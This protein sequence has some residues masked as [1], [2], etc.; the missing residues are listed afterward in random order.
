MKNTLRRTIST[1]LRAEAL[2]EALKDLQYHTSC[3]HLSP[4]DLLHEANAA[5][6]RACHL[7]CNLPS[8]P[9]TMHEKHAHFAIRNLRRIIRGS[10]CQACGLE[11]PAETRELAVAIAKLAVRLGNHQGAMGAQELLWVATAGQP[12]DEEWKALEACEQV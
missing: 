4:L 7:L 12:T 5:T 11:S 8:D 10:V 3:G 9:T 1:G 2:T 6:S